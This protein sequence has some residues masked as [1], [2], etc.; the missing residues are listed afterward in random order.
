ML[1]RIYNDDSPL[2]DN[3]KDRSSKSRTEEA[4]DA[5]P[6]PL[7]PEDDEPETPAPEVDAAAV[8]EPPLNAQ[9][10][11]EVVAA[12]EPGIEEDKAL[13]DEDRIMAA[14]QQKA[15]DTKELAPGVEDE[16]DVFN[17]TV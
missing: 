6:G 16:E 14:A 1:L 9:R 12:L 4:G 2:V 7:E 11:T 15:D 13:K 17:R 10:A 8:I 5:F 3:S